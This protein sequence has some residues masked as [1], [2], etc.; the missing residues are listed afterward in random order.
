MNETI[1]KFG[2]PETLVAEYTHWVVLLR[3]AQPT[4]GSLVLAAKSEASRFPDLGGMLY[5][6]VIEVAE[7]RVAAFLQSA[8]PFRAADTEALRL[9]RLFL[10][11]TTAPQRF[12]TQMAASEPAP[13]HPSVG[14]PPSPEPWIPFAVRFFLKALPVR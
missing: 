7:K 1:A 14:A 2:Y 4:L 12:A 11:M 5:R 9:A 3:P 13:E 10:N 6:D 8:A